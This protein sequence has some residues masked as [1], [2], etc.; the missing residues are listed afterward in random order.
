[1]KVNHK[2]LSVV[3]GGFLLV[4]LGYIVFFTNKSNTIIKEKEIQY[5]E[6]STS[7]SELEK[8]HQTTLSKLSEAESKIDN[9]S[10]LNVTTNKEMSSLKKRIKSILYKSKV[11]RQE[12]AKAEGLIVQLNTKIEEHLKENV[13]LKENNA[14]LT[15]DNSVLQTEKIE[16]TTALATTKS[17]KEA[18]EEKVNIGS[19]LSISNFSVLGLNEKGKKT[20]VAENVDKFKL[21]FQINENRIS[22]SGIKTVYFVVLNPSGKVIEIPGQSG[23]ILTKDGDKVYSTKSNLDYATGAVKSVSFDVDVDKISSDGLY[24]ILVYENGLKIGDKKV[25]LKKKKFLGL[26]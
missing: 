22:N 6:V 19:T 11:T 7:K 2:L 20:E 3:F 17:E 12:L 5:V 14:K 9:L 10:N 15:N 25:V 18:A 1:M 23:L 8:E 13:V 24:Q 4:S 16:L 21:S 26:L